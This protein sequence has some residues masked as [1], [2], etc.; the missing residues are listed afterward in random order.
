M[1]GSDPA[2]MSAA[3]GGTWRWSELPAT[4]FAPG[5]DLRLFGGEQVTVSVAEM[6][7]GVVV[8][9]HAHPHEQVTYV[10]SG[11]LAV[12]LGEQGAL[13]ELT[14]GPGEISYVPGLVPHE[15]TAREDTVFIEIFAPRRDDLHAK[16]EGERGEEQ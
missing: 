14:V 9:R 4:S 8:P 13:R 7:A 15:T 16:V 6:A 2:R 12:E 5:L 3:G 1:S 11:Q 10:V